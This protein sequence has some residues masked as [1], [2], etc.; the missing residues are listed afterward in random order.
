ME[1]IALFMLLNTVE[2]AS[3]LAQVSGPGTYVNPIRIAVFAVLFVAWAFACQWADRDSDLVKT[4]RE[5]WNLIILSG[6]ITGL[7]LCVIV[8][9]ALGSGIGA[10]VLGLAFWIMLAGGALLAYVIH[11]NG[12]VIANARVLTLGHFKRLFERG[13]GKKQRVDKGQRVR[14]G[15]HDGKVAEVPEDPEEYDRYAATQEFLFDALWRRSSDVDMVVGKDKA[16]LVYRID[17]AS[18][19]QQDRISV[20]D[21]ERVVAYIKSLASLNPE[22]RRRPQSGKIQ[23]GLLATPEMAPVNVFTSGST[24][25]ERLRLAIQSAE[26][27]KRLGDLGLRESD[28]KTLKEL[29]EQ[30]TGLV[31]FAGPKQSGVT[32]TQYAVIRDHDAFMQNLHSLERT[33]LLELDNI[34]QNTYDSSGNTVSYARQLQSVLRREPDVVLVGECSDRETAQIAARAAAADRKIYLALEAGDA[35]TALAKFH[36]LVEDNAQ[37]SKCL[38]AVTNQRLVRQLCTACREAFKPDERLLKKLNLPV[39]KIEHFHRPPTQPITDRKGNEVICQTCQG[40]GYV[41]RTGIFEILKVDDTVRGLL[42]EGAPIQRIKDHFRRLRTHDLWRA[43]LQKVFDGQT[44]L[45]E[46]LRVLRPGGK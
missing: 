5:Q 16:R 9:L 44:S 26:S 25:G 45:D 29:I 22:E 11:R 17:G 41:G 30:R 33:A 38:L 13:G 39:G 18:I 34:T 46:I 7:A 21:A 4:H 28:R 6:G 12:R 40:T 37:L 3:I 20:E 14:V 19:E 32:T 42:A 23:A 36:E 15:N 27:C 8:P 10:F 2:V 35:F 31:I 43:G 24:T 1:P